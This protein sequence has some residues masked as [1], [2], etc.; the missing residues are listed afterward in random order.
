MKNLTKKLLIIKE[1]KK[2]KT[3]R[4]DFFF[5]VDERI[6]DSYKGRNDFFPVFF[7]KNLE[8][9]TPSRFDF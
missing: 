7:R 6:L 3:A 8:S 1:A 2:L 9:L 5:R 4:K